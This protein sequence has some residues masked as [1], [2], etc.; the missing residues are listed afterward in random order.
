LLPSLTN[1]G[2]GQFPVWLLVIGGAALGWVRNFW[3]WLYG[4]TVGQITQRVRVSVRIEETDHAEAFLWLSHWVELKLAARRIALLQ[5]RRKQT[6][7]SN[8]DGPCDPAY[9]TSDYELVPA[10]GFYPFLWKRYFLAFDSG[11]KNE[12]QA[13]D[14]NRS[15]LFGPRRHVELTIWGTRDRSLL[16]E[17]LEE[18]RRAWEASHPTIQQYY[19]HRYS[20]WNS[21]PLGRRTADT[22]YLPH[23]TF[24][25]IADDAR[26]FLQ[27]QRMFEELGI[28]WRRGYLFYGPP[29]TGKTTL[30]HVLATELGLP[31]YYLSL[32]AIR[33][34]ED[35]ANLLDSVRPGSIVLIEDID[36]ISA[37]VARMN[38]PEGANAAGT[39]PGSEQ[40]A[41]V[42]APAP[43]ASDRLTPGDLLN[44]ID[45]IVAS[46]GR[47]LIMTTNYPQNLDIALVRP[48]RVD[49]RWHIDYAKEPEILRFYGRAKALGHSLIDEDEFL[50]SL[51]PQPTIAAA[52][53]LLLKTRER[54]EELVL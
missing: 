2:L 10:Y 3:T 24:E 31:L 30:V 42:Q 49:R 48:G 21:K 36:C 51:G 15:S 4:H 35:L 54:E 46:E 40:Q 33:S 12:A 1:P 32:A 23:G 6:Q 50:E 41:K 38:Q 20:Y 5:L 11:E 19:Y 8:L 7:H 25:E 18:A 17:V 43:T 34:R 39:V 52:Q 13:P 37:A 9:P 47:L 53:V 22:I 27:N 45:G 14:S 26:Q 29:G 16:L 44:Q 28:P